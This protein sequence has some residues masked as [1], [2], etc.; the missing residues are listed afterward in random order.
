MGEGQACHLIHPAATFSLPK[1]WGRRIGAGI[2][3]NQKGLLY[4]SDEI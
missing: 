3:R 4:G 2:Q 1:E